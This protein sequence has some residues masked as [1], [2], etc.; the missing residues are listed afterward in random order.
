[1]S[2]APPIIKIDKLNFSYHDNPVLENV[3]LEIEKG[4][5]ASIVGPNG[6]GKTTLL[7]L[8][9]GLLKPVSGKLEIFGRPPEKARCKIGYMP[10]HAELDPQFPISVLDVVL[11]G[12]IDQCGKGFFSGA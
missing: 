2:T 5:L 9:L 3:N 10:Q 7:K 11:M 12:Q 8:I 4:E 6:G 1:M